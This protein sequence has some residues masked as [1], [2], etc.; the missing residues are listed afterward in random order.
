L[1]LYSV[2]D[3]MHD[4]RVSLVISPVTRKEIDRVPI[5]HRAPH[6]E[7][8]ESLAK[9]PTVDEQVLVPH[10]VTN[11]SV[12]RA[13]ELQDPGT[14][15]FAT[16]DLGVLYSGW[17]LMSWRL[18]CWKRGSHWIARQETGARKVSLS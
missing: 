1:A 16:G 2:I 9:I 13:R 17:A 4:G 11:L 7:I 5:E 6:E 8:Y 3:L 15:R 14:I 10:M 18:R 12:G